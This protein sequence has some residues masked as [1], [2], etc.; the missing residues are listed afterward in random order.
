MFIL[1]EDAVMVFVL[2]WV[3]FCGILMGRAEFFPQQIQDGIED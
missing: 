1:I 2:L 3:R